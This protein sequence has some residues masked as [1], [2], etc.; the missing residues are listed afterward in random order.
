MHLSTGF[1]LTG[2]DRRLAGVPVSVGVCVSMQVHTDTERG[3]DKDITRVDGHGHDVLLDSSV[4]LVF[5]WK[6]KHCS[7]GL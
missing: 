3:E 7:R 1:G 4:V 5:L 6:L 2:H